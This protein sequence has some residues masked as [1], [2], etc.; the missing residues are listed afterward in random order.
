LVDAYLMTVTVVSR[1]LNCGERGDL[2]RSLR[3]LQHFEK[4]NALRTADPFWS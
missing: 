3:L 1:C 4:P 2:N